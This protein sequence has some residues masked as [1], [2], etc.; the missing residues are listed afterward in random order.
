M[1]TQLNNTTVACRANVLVEELPDDTIVLIDED[2][3][4]TYSINASGRQIWS[5]LEQERLLGELVEETV[6]EF[7][8]DRGVAEQDIVSFLESLKDCGLVTLQDAE[9]LR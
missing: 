6:N 7:G 1:N 9:G 5:R 4:V 8:V 2:R 3:R